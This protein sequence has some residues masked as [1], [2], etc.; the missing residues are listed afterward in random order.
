M[1]KVAVLWQEHWEPT[2]IL[3]AGDPE[4]LP[5][6]KSADVVDL[7]SE[8]IKRF[9]DAKREMEEVWNL[10]RLAIRLQEDDGA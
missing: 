7:S 10:M 1:P 9:E 5:R 3:E 4:V 6:F 2:T 8:F